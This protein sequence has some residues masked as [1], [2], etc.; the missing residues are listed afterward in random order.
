[1][2]AKKVIVDGIKKGLKVGSE[3]STSAC[4]EMVRKE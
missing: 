2:T 4:S 1:M 3:D